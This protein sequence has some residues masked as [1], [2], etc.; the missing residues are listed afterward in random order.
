M[1]QFTWL[2]LRLVSIDMGMR[3]GII[4]VA[5]TSRGK[6]PAFVDDIATLMIPNIAIS[7]AGSRDGTDWR[8]GRTS[9]IMT[10]LSKDSTS[11]P[12]HIKQ[13]TRT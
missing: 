10:H 1:E 3:N 5:S 4:L 6:P 12:R 2:R 7:T 11:F 13:L 9:S 8:S